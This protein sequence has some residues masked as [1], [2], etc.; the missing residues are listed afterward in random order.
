MRC[1][2]RVRNPTPNCCKQAITLKTP[3]QKVNECNR[4]ITL[5]TAWSL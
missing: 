4:D 1:H 2:S 3:S 5:T